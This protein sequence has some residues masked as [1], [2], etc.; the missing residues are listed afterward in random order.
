MALVEAVTATTAVASSLLLTYSSHLS[1]VY[2]FDKTFTCEVRNLQLEI[3]SADK[4]TLHPSVM[5]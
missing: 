3:L 4:K 2:I 5:S 1:T